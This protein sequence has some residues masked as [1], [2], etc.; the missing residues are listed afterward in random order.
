MGIFSAIVAGIAL[1]AGA[2]SANESSKARKEANAYNK[3]AANE[4]KLA[5]REEKALS[6]Q[7][8]ANERRSQVREERVRRAKILQAAENSGS[9]GSSG[10][11]GATAGMATQLQANIGLNLGRMQG[12]NLISGYMQNAADFNTAAQSA[13]AKSQ[14]F[15]ALAGLSMSIFSS[16]GGF[17]AFGTSKGK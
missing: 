10:E 9:A 7:Q 1:V 12:A 17:G 16:A 3:K 15:D 11:Y 8:A 14:D 2:Y 4:Q 13:M 6:Y 5:R